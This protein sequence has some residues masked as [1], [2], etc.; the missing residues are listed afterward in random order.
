MYRAVA[1]RVEHVVATALPGQ[2]AR[3]RHEKTSLVDGEV[4]AELMVAGSNLRQKEKSIKA[5]I[6]E[7]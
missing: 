1:P 6:I 7:I 5:N 4:V 2:V 3:A